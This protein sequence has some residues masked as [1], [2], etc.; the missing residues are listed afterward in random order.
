MASLTRIARATPTVVYRHTRGLSRRP[1]TYVSVCV[2]A[3]CP[4]R[5]GS[6]AATPAVCGHD[7]GGARKDAGAAAGAV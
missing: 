5:V 3:G 7:A 6:A 2:S 1:C 4:A